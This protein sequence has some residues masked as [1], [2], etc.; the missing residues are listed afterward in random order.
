VRVT[1]ILKKEEKKNFR[2]EIQCSNVTWLISYH[3]L[4][5]FVKGEALRFKQASS[6]EFCPKYVPMQ[7]ERDC[8]VVHGSNGRIAGSN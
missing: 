2:C 7:F 4:C 6:K 8:F 3:H 1:I 5:L